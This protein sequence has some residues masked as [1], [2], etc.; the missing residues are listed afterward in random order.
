MGI[1]EMA[2]LSFASSK[3]GAG[4]STSVILL[5]TQLAAKGASVTVID[6]DPN[7]PIVRW[8]RKP[9]RPDS[10]TVIGDVTEESLIDQVEEASA[11]SSFVIVDLEG[12]A[13]MMVAQAMSRSDLV[14]IPT[15]GSALDAV[16]A[17]KAVKFIRFQEKNY[18]T[19][20]PFAVLFTQTSAAIRPRTLTSIE[21]E[22]VAKEVP[23][24]NVQIHDRDAYRALFTFGGT[25][26]TLD[27]KQVRNLPAS[28]ENAK[29][30]ANEVIRT[31]DA[32]RAR[33]AA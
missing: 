31:L 23:L 13:N 26:A 18:R 24:F 29:A 27:G 22:F 5:G 2:V 11:R 6:A 15:R 3:G 9:G 19:K 12:T 25:L 30:F 32:N 8:A 21:A 14:I 7:Q 28:I 33:R 16:E 4:K 20:I 17:F 1:S 10:L